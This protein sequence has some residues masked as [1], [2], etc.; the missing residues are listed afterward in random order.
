MEVDDAVSTVTLS[1]KRSEAVEVS[2]KDFSTPLHSAQND[3]TQLTPSDNSELVS[4][5]FSSGKKNGCRKR[6][7]FRRFVENQWN[8]RKR[9]NQKTRC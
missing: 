3:K 6:I 7:E 5:S 8:W 9:K 2:N 1:T 4:F